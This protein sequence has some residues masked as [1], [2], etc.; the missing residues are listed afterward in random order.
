MGNPTMRQPLF[1]SLA[2]LLGL[3]CSI[4]YALTGSL[5]A[6]TFVHWLAVNLWIFAGAGQTHRSTAKSKAVE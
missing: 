4:A 1:L 6:I 5:V 2:G 3:T